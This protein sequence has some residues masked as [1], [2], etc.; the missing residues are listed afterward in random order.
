VIDYEEA[1]NKLL[2][3]ALRRT[4]GNVLKAARLLNMPAHR[5]RYRLKKFN[6]NID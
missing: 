5:I 4:G 3:E 1:I 6:L 2:Q